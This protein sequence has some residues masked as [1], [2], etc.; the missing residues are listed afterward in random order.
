[1]KTNWNV[2]PAI[3]FRDEKRYELRSE[4][5]KSRRCL[6]NPKST[7]AF[8]GTSSTPFDTIRMKK[9]DV[10]ALI[11]VRLAMD[12]HINFSSTLQEAL[13]RKLGV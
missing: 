9:N 8:A 1:M 12:S 10:V 4:S 7:K 3:F 13:R 6:P 11:E 5:K 2:F